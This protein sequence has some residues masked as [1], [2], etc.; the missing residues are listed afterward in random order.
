[1]GEPEI[2]RQIEIA[3]FAFNIINKLVEAEKTSGLDVGQC[4]RANVKCVVL[5]KVGVVL[6]SGSNTLPDCYG[7]CTC[8]TDNADTMK[9]GSS[10]CRAVHAEVGALLDASRGHFTLDDIHYVVST[11]PPCKNCLS[12]LLKTKAMFIVAPD[13]WPDRDD[14]MSHWRNAGRHWFTIPKSLLE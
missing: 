14:S 10:T 12:I 3:E 1:M 8:N 9:Q 13:N 11:R 5:N 4:P 2:P 6:G 7:S